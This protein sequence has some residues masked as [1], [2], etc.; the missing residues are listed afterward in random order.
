[1]RKKT[2]FASVAEMVR[3]TTDDD[4]FAAAFEGRLRGRGIVKELMVLRAVRGLSQG[5]VASRLG[6]TQSR[7]SKL[8]SSA[9]ADIR[10]GDLARYASAVGFRVDVVL[11]SRETTAVERVKRL[12]ARIKDQLDHLA[13]LA[14]GDRKIA[15]GVASFFNEAF[16]DLVKLLQGS[17]EKL[18]RDAEDGEP[19]LSFEILE[20]EPSVEAVPPDAAPRDGRRSSDR[21]RSKPSR[22]VV[23]P[24]R[25]DDAL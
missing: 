21:K 22:R 17:A 24:G 19:P 3:E 1:M 11:E 16:F 20:G 6:C 13:G 12:A 10:L 2:T 9:D 14:R 4:A 18:P 7:I 15:Q 8:E 5:D 25:G 23:L